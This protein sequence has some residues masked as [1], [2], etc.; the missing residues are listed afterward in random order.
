M[1]YSSHNIVKI[2]EKSSYIQQHL[3][4]EPTSIDL[5]LIL[6]SPSETNLARLRSFCTHS[7][8][9]YTAVLSVYYALQVP[10]GYIYTK[11]V[12]F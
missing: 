10:K 8:G 3:P 6:N 4:M 12:Y 1:Q 7:R 11:H 9:A 2:V 5:K